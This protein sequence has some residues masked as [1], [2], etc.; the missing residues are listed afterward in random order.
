MLKC[1]K[2][3]CVKY[4]NYTLIAH[5]CDDN[6]HQNIIISDDITGSLDN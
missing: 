6:A 3:V 2:L 5:D 4:N 1:L